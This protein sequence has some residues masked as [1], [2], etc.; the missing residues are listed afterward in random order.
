MDKLTLADIE[1]YRAK[2]GDVVLA[3]KKISSLP[4]NLV[5]KGDLI[6]SRSNIT[7]LPENLEVRGS[8]Y[9]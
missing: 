8:L 7:A 1:K 5:V 6:L 2:N 9:L 4:D 3:D